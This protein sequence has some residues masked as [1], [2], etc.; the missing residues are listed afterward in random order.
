MLW[1]LHIGSGLLAPCVG[2]IDSVKRAACGLYL[3]EVS[4]PVAQCVW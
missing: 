4:D 3:H 1:P 2:G